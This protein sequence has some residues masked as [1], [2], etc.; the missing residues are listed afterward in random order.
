[1]TTDLVP[2]RFAAPFSADIPRDWLPSC[3]AIAALLDTYTIMVP[4][5]EGFFMRTVNGCLPRLRDPGLRDAA[6][7]FIHQEAEHGVAHR[8]YWRHLEAQGYRFRGF[9]RLVE[10]LTFRPVEKFAPLA[11][12]L[13]MMSCVEHINAFI[14]HEC[15][16]RDILADAHPEVRALME[17][18]FAEEIEHK[19]VAFE[20]FETA[21]PS[22]ALRL[23]GL[24]TAA[25][26]FYA[27]IGCGA[28]MLLAQNRRL[29]RLSTWT[30]LW[31]HVGGGHRL[32]TRTLAHLWAYAQPSFRP[33][34]LDDRALAAAVIARHGSA[35]TA[36]LAPAARGARPSST[37][38]AP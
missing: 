11:L 33:E 19:Q 18:H 34:R 31:R 2:R 24:A 8:R 27:V 36:W 6:R 23:L 14:A 22:Y 7:A 35:G 28:L 16:S 12:R 15:L 32:L 1:M 30:G 3:P 25:P 17:W 29:L 20:V 38:A 10:R 9:E 13:S 5:N 4:A 37:P 26:L 21:V